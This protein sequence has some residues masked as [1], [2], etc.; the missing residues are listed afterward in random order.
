MFLGAFGFFFNIIGI[1]MYIEGK[2][3]G[4]RQHPILSAI[5]LLLFLAAGVLFIQCMRAKRGAHA[6]T[7][8]LRN[9]MATRAFVVVGAEG[10]EPPTYWV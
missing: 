1:I 10:L 6:E 8:S 2:G 3:D 4:L 7:Q 9:R 5:T